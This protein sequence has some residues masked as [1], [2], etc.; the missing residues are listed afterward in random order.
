[1]LFWLAGAIHQW[2]QLEPSGLDEA[3]GKTLAKSLRLCM[4]K[5]TMAQTDVARHVSSSLP[6]L[7]ADSQVA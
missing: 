4:F 5:Q 1:M 3:A 6:S 2:Q 7:R